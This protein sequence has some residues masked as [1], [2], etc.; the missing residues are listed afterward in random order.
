MSQQDLVAHA[1]S[2]LGKPSYVNSR[3]AGEP[4]VLYIHPTP[5]CKDHIHKTLSRFTICTSI[6]VLSSFYPCP[7]KLWI[8]IWHLLK[9]KFQTRKASLHR[10]WQ[11]GMC[12]HST[13]TV[14]CNIFL[15]CG[16]FCSRQVCCNNHLTWNSVWKLTEDTWLQPWY[17]PSQAGGCLNCTLTHKKHQ[18][19]MTSSDQNTSTQSSQYKKSLIKRTTMI[20]LE[21][22]SCRK[23]NKKNKDFKHQYKLDMERYTS[24]LLFPEIWSYLF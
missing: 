4:R 9:G 24:V 1:R 18:T 12:L 13:Q 21:R 14:V 15:R 5:A 8:C 10:V 6:R 16:W 17:W 19:R 7:S 3:H 23:K 20:T 2:E 11:N 22:K